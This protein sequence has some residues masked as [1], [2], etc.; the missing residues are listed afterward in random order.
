[1]II[2]IKNATATPRANEQVERLHRTP[3]TATMTKDPEGRDWD[4]VL[5]QPRA[6][7]GNQLQNEAEAEES[8]EVGE[9]RRQAIEKIRR[10]QEK[11]RERYNKRRYGNDTLVEGDLVLMKHEPTATG[12]CRKLA[13]K[14]KGPYIVIE[15]LPGDRYT[16]NCQ[17]T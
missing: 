3:A 1:Y 16:P 5:R 15:L 14:Y 4:A 17:R 2:H 12:T 11:Q 10:D 13:E 6:Y 8:K 7:H 9:M